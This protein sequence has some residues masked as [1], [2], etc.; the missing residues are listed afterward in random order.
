ML[1]R[2]CSLRWEKGP[3]NFS[4]GQ[5]PRIDRSNRKRLKARSIFIGAEDNVHAEKT[6]MKRAFSPYGW[7]TDGSWGVAPG[8]DGGA[9]LALGRM[10]G[11]NDKKRDQQTTILV[12]KMLA[13]HRQ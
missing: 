3:F 13:L 8:W 9:P 4:L 2:S 12:G 7:L 11:P 10:A 5:R 1:A 6:L